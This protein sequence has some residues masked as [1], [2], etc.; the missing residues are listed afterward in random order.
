MEPIL[1]SIKEVEGNTT[2]VVLST[3]E[4][5][6]RWSVGAAWR[7]KAARAEGT[8]HR[9]GAQASAARIRVELAESIST[10]PVCRP[11]DLGFGGHGHRELEGEELRVLHFSARF[12]DARELA[13][14][15]F[16]VSRALFSAKIC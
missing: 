2:T 9:L 13:N 8:G 3:A 1:L 4:K 10:I 14:R 15:V 11:A 5:I 16:S 7:K 12:W 6:L